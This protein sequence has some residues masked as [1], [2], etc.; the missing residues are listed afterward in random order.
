[1]AVSPNPDRN[2]DIMKNDHGTLCLITDVQSDHYLNKVKY[3]IPEDRY[4]RPCGGKN[5]FDDYVERWH[6]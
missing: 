4:S 6:E 3:T 5:G 2:I 1:M